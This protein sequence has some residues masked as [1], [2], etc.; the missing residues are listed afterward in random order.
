MMIMGA[1][2]ALAVNEMAIRLVAFDYD[3][4]IPVEEAPLYLF[5]KL[6]KKAES[7]ALAGEF[8][9]GLAAAKTEAERDAV[10]GRV[11]E[12]SF[13]LYRQFPL[14]KLKD[15]IKG[16]KFIK[17]TKETFNYLKGKGIRTAILTATI[18]PIIKWSLNEHGL[19]PDELVASQCTA[20]NGRLEKLVSVV[21]PMGKRRRLAAILR[22]NGFKPTE[23]LVLG[24]AFSEIP[25]FNLVGKENSV[26]F[27][28]QQ[29]L[30]QHCAHLLFKQGDPDRDL[31]KIIGIIEEKDII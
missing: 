29:D 10:P 11:W 2:F 1:K 13:A 18:K 23:C 15:V 9:S 19:V 6:G 14:R 3:G 28:Y 25:M 31:R 26:A 16:L 12:K 7:D 20:M 4:V 21:S 27:N 22:E 30:Q 24:D 8:Y 17:G 5:T